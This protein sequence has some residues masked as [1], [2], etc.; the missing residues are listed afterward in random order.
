MG[1]KLPLLETHLQ[2]LLSSS[3]SS[4]VLFLAY[5]LQEETATSS[6]LMNTPPRAQA[7]ERMARVAN[8]LLQVQ[9][10]FLNFSPNILH[11]LKLHWSSVFSLDQS[12]FNLLSKKKLKENL[13]WLRATAWGMLSYFPSNTRKITFSF[14]PKGSVFS[15]PPAERGWCFPAGGGN[16]RRQ[17]WSTHCTL[18]AGP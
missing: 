14:L 3:A 12:F 18:S 10:L 2:R 7:K 6:V 5:L 16:Y 11:L 1:I 17:A 13:R 4:L 8:F 15:K 9:V